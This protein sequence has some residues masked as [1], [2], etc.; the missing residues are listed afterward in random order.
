MTAFSWLWLLMGFVLPVLALVVVPWFVRLRSL[1]LAA[2]TCLL[3]VVPAYTLWAVI[4]SSP[5]WY[6]STQIAW[7]GVKASGVPL[8][9]GGKAEQSIVGWPTNQEEPQ[10][11]FSSTGD[12][13][14][15]VTLEIKDGGAFVFDDSREQPLNGDPI[16]VGQTR[17]FGDYKIRV[18]RLGLSFTF[19]RPEVEVLDA[20][21]RS[22]AGFSLREE[23][24]RSLLH[25]ISSTPME[26]LDELPD[27][28]A[29]EQVVAARQKLEEWAAGIWLYRN[30]NDSVQVLTRNSSVTHN[31]K[32]GTVLSVKWPTVSL[33]F[34]AGARRL[35][36]SSIQQQ[37]IFRAPWRLTS[38]LPPAQI[39]GCELPPGMNTANRNLVL[40][41]I[42]Q[43]CDIAFVLPLGGDAAAFRH[44]VT[45]SADSAKFNTAD[46]VDNENQPE[47][48]PG[49]PEEPGKIGTSQISREQGPYSFDFATVKNLPSR[50]KI[51]VLLFMT[52]GVFSFGVFLALPRMLAVNLR[53]VYGLSLLV[54]DLLCLRLL[55]SFRYALDPAALDP[56][57][58]KGVTLAF[59]GLTVTPGLILLMARLRADRFDG[60]VDQADK[61]GAMR[62][63]LVY[64]LL[65]I[66]T[67]LIA[68][69]VTPGL[70]TGLPDK[71]YIGFLDLFFSRLAFSLII[72][73][74]ILLIALHARFLYLPDSLKSETKGN[75]ARIFVSSWYRIESYF[76]AGKNFWEAQLTGGV[77]KQLY[78]LRGG[79]MFLVLFAISFL[80][81]RLFPAGDKTAQ[82]M[83]V[84]I[85]F[86]WL[87]VVWLG[88][89]LFFGSHRS[90]SPIGW[91]GILVLA[92][93][94]IGMIT[95]PSI[96]VP[97]AIGDFGSIVPV[98]A[99]VLP[100][101][102][103]LLWVLPNQA[104][105]SVL[106][107][108]MLI[109]VAGFSL[110]QNIEGLIPFHKQIVSLLPDS[111]ARKEVVS[112]SPGR[113]FARL[114]NYKKGTAAQAFAITANSIAGGEGLGYQELLNG[115]QHTWEN[116][117]I[118]HR[119]GWTGLGYGRAPNR[120]SN[121]RQDTLQYDSVFSFFVVSEYGF[122]GGLLVMLL[123][124]IPLVLIFVAGKQRFD[125][126]YALAF[127]IAS[128]F[129]L[130]AVY[131]MGMN[132]GSFPMTG[133]NLPL[134][135]VNSPTDLIR[136][137]IVFAFAVT[138]IFWRYKGGGALAAESPSLI[139][140]SKTSS[141]STLS[142]PGFFSGGEPTW[143][144]ALVFFVVPVFFATA[145]LYSGLGVLVDGNKELQSYN[146]EQMTKALDYYINH[147]IIEFKNDRLIPH[148]EKL[149][150]PDA[151]SFF[152]REIIRFNLQ[153]PV[154]QEE[155]FRKEYIT[156][157]NDR[158]RSV[159]TVGEY[160]DALRE[161]GN[162]KPPPRR[163]NIFELEVKADEDGNITEKTVKPSD[164]Y[165]ID[166]NFQDDAGRNVPKVAYGG[167]AIIGPAWIR[168]RV[169][170]VVSPEAKLPWIR[171]LRDA[172]LSDEAAAMAW[173]NN[174]QGLTLSL[175]SA[176][177]E[178]AIDFVTAKGLQLHNTSLSSTRPGKPNEPE[179]L[180]RLPKRV[181]LSVI[182]LTNGR[183]LALGGWPRMSSRRQWVQ[184]SVTVGDS[185]TMFWLPTS[186]WL[187]REA[188]R[189]LRN[190]YVGERNFER[191]LVM[192]SSTK[193]IWAA[194]VL[195]T[196]PNLS[197][198][199]RVRGSKG[200][201][202]SA[203]GIVLSNKAWE[204]NSHSTNWIDFD[205]YLKTSDNRFHIRLGLLGLASS[206]QGQIKSGG[207]SPSV[208]ESLS[209][210]STPWGMYPDFISPIQVLTKS[211]HLEIDS[212]GKPPNSGLANSELAKNLR[213][214]FSI[215]VTR[216]PNTSKRAGEFGPRR[217]FWTKDEANDYAAT[218]N[219]D[220]SV[221]DAISPQAPDFQFDQ[222]T[223]PRDFISMLLGGSYNSW[224][225]V[226]VAAAFGTCL[227]GRPVVAHIVANDA[228]VKPFSERK[229]LDPAI[230]ATLRPGLNAVAESQGGTAY[231]A[232]H[233]GNALTFLRNAGIK[234]YAKTGTL[235]ASED[236][237]ATSR[238]LL[239]LVKWKDEQKG[240][241]EA[242]LVFS[243]V[244]EEARTGTAAIWIRDFIMEHQTDISRLMHMGTN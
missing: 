168:G 54:W 64:L 86:M 182:D 40:T 171:Q 127:I 203:F 117:A 58:I 25:S 46:A 120:T 210:G 93:A 193:P 220:V 154:E 197:K 123:Y 26:D 48:P 87:A 129:F 32:S 71:Y 62:Q 149:E 180:N 110:Y 151:K 1:H 8:S 113:L 88:L 202:N 162:K 211:G 170:A 226:D 148:P 56:H 20:G 95:V 3:A 144:Y 181:A 82:E 208:D 4:F 108:G 216:G 137:T 55:L 13:I 224:S 66:V 37:V 185:E 14:D 231:R 7:T 207:K 204:L 27:D 78:F 2:L 174:G 23:R 139:D 104:R 138:V 100:L 143:K 218:A 121:V 101:C 140:D 184:S 83:S 161:L 145:V 18:N 31:L 244:A 128:M 81:L 17:D 59:V 229:L 157:L 150:D 131:H 70:W 243:L 122:F 79:F 205:E 163:R 9:I 41:G 107:A 232:L 200:E 177:H 166:F 141:V 106:L 119:G 69:Y 90:K 199:L 30:D 215:G 206:A 133:R 111:I 94:A 195:K 179:Y 183:T 118:A 189:G 51:F 147:N 6:E 190:R 241:V 67:G 60:P 186:Q 223:T 96:L 39:T 76:A 84:P 155:R 80:L 126:G 159:K 242:G 173:K 188:P 75:L 49:V 219:S 239:A 47:R 116:R 91:K 33:T 72:L 28:A 221:F 99:I 97:V 201:E 29:R 125:G 134:L 209:G 10:L 178:A 22:L 42:A 57:A 102:W 214:M 85:L 228:P 236:E 158:L 21:G 146:Y 68:G 73:I 169:Q 112:G 63:A 35:R 156:E 109:F 50:P 237:I 114:L 19:W 103:L 45:L 172:V 196:H 164:D 217:S 74:A 11:I 5:Y 165:K 227:L 92:I 132:V 24:T 105:I 142:T 238:I 65:L 234:I 34:E 160:N 222:L 153:D 152:Q 212:L 53:L 135:S 115:N 38:P 198:D 98:L 167:H 61:K 77:K 233:E 225:N 136:W 230:A 36:D 130:E 235:K 124:A 194:A 175:D 89:R 16:P 15:Q 44:A 12:Q 192:G 52:L 240:E 176:L 191:V 43:P 213:G 187:D